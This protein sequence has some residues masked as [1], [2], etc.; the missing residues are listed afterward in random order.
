M[1]A[2]KKNMKENTKNIKPNPTLSSEYET[3][4]S[5]LNVYLTE[6]CHR[7]EFMWLQLFRFYFAILI[8]ILLPN[9]VGISVELP[10]IPKILFRIAGIIFSFIYV[11]V[12]MAYVMRF[13]KIADSYNNIIKKLPEDYQRV[14]MG[15]TK[16]EKFFSIR[17]TYLICSILFLT[18]VTVSILLLVLD[19]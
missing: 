6:W 18:L 19:I 14:S 12:A 15:K 11:Y 7:E 5:L 17:V 9:L 1:Y 16:L 10:Y 2:R 8:V 13:Q 3:T 4:I